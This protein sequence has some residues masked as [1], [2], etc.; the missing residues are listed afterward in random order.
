MIGVSLADLDFFFYFFFVSIETRNKKYVAYTET[1]NSKFQ[2]PVPVI[3]M[4][5]PPWGCI[6]SVNECK[7]KNKKEKSYGNQRNKSDCKEP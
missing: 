3:G 5:I 6:R 2:T 1:R 4:E 7:T